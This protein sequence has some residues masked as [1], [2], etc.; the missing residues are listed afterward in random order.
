MSGDFAVFAAA[1]GDENILVGRMYSHRRPGVESTSFVYDGRFLASPDGF[2]LDPALPLVTGTLQTPVN[3][4][5]F[6]AFADS[7]PDRWGRMLI[8]RA[9]RARASAAGTTPRSMSEVDLLLGVRDDLRQGALRFR[10]D[11]HGPFLATEDAG[12]PLLTDLPALLDIA[13]RVEQDTAGYDELRRLLRAGSSLGGARPKAH[14]LDEAGCLAIAKFP[15]ASSDTWNVMAWEKV[16]LDLARDAGVTVPGSQLIRVGDRHVLIVDRF[17]RHGAA[18]I[19]Y[20]SAMTMLEARDGDQRS[21]LEIA[22]V[23]EERST[24]ATAELRQLWRRMAFSVLISNTDDHLRNHGFLHQHGDS[25]MLS[26]AF[27]LNPNPTPGPRHLS[28]AIDFD[29][30]R[31]KVD[32]LLEVAEFFRLDAS[33]ALEVL[34]EVTQATASW[35]DVATSH[36]L[37]QR[38]L[39]DM[40][41]AFEHAEAEQ[42]RALTK[43]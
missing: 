11:D 12:V 37:A 5:L 27:D 20:A 14:V 21:Y 39:D 3:R 6:G 35:R 26:P 9:E 1:A 16:A 17:D 40:E 2:A 38:D 4:A 42:A 29:D 22:A 31:A 8:R 28:T 30:T 13:A 43:G 18:R 23:I 41:P 19:G 36:G 7:L 33:S 25:W 32:T 34:G 10:A 24:A 15:S